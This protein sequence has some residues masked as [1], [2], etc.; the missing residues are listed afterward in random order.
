MIIIKFRQ[1]LL[2]FNLRFTAFTASISIY[3]VPLSCNTELFSLLTASS[4]LIPHKI[5]LKS[6]PFTFNIAMYFNS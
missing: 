5:Y 1:I 3:N 4:L 6:T 2:R